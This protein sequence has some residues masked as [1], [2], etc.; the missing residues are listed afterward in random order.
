MELEKYELI[1]KIGGGSYG[2]VFEAKEKL[3]GRS[4]AVKL[5]SKVRK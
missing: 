3:T 1:K 4:I 5:I 2:D